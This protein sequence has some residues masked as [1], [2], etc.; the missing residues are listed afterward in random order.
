M[1]LIRGSLRLRRDDRRPASIWEA[2]VDRGSAVLS[3]AT[4]EVV[5]EE[6]NVEF[7]FRNIKADAKTEPKVALINLLMRWWRRIC[8]VSE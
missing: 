4:G 5:N 2:M 7:V 3:L 6:E 8:W 1:R